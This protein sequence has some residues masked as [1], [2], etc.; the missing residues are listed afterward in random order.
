MTPGLRAGK[1]HDEIAQGHGADGRVGGEG[2][3]FKLVVSAL[4]VGAEKFFG[5]DVAGAGGPARADGGEL[6]RVLV[7]G[8]AVEMLLGGC[9][10]GEERAR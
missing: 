2:V 7:G 9:G 4:E 3:F 6:A 5:F 1:A 8:C 10:E